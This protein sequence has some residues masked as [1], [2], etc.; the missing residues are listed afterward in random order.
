MN[1]Y[2][3]FISLSKKKVSCCIPMF[4]VM[5]FGVQEIKGQTSFYSQ[6]FE[7]TND[8]TF[9]HSI[10]SNNKNYWVFGLGTA[11]ATTGDATHSGTGSLQIWQSDISATYGWNANYSNSATNQYDRTAS[12]TFNFSSIPCG[13][14]VTFKYWVLCKGETGYDDLTVSVNSNVIQGPLSGITSWQQK[15]ID[16]SSFVGNSNV[17][18]SFN[19]RNN[20][21]NK[22]QPAARIDDIEIT[23]TP[24]ITVTPTTATICPNTI[25]AITATTPAT[26]TIVNETF[27][28]A[29]FPTNWATTV[30][31]GDAVTISSTNYA[32]GSA[33]EVEF[34]SNSQT[35]NIIDRLKYGPFNTSG[36]TSLTLSW[37]NYLWHYSSVYS[38]YV[39]LQTSSDGITWHDSTWGTNPV[40]AD[41]NQ[42]TE[43]ITLATADIGSSTTYISFTMGGLTFGAFYWYIDDVILKGSGFP[44]WAPITYL[45]SNSGATASYIL[46]TQAATVYFKSSTPGIYPYTATINGCTAT[47]TITVNALNTAAAAS[48]TPT[49]CVNTALTNITHVTTGATGISNSGVSGA[50]GLPAGL[51]AS[52][53]S[54]TITI[55]GTPTTSGTFN[56]SISLTGGCGS[57]NATGTITVTPLLGFVNLQ[58]PASG[59]IC[60]SGSFTA[61]G[62]VY[63]SGV[64]PGV[65]AGAGITVQFGYSFSNSDPSTWITWATANYNTDNGNNDE[66]QYTLNSLLAGTY[67]YAFRYSNGTCNWQ[68]GGYNSGGGGTWNGTSN[69]SGVLTVIAVPTTAAAG[70]DQT[71]CEGS[72]ITLAANSPTV[73]SGQWSIISGS[74][75]SIATISSPTSTFTGTI[76]TTYTLRW[77]TTNGICTT[78][79]DVVIT[80]SGINWANTQWPPNALICTNGSLTVFGQIYVAGL[81]NPAGAGAGIVAQLG[82]STTN[83]NPN[84]WTNW[85]PSVIN[86][87][88]LITNNNDEYMATLSG[89]SAA[90]YYYAFRYSLNGCPYKYGGNLNGTWNGVN[91]VTGDFWNGTTYVGGVLTVNQPNVTISG[92]TTICS[93]SSTT[94]TANGANTYLW[95]NSLTSNPITVSPPTSTTYTVTGTNSNNCTNTA[96]INVTVNPKPISTSIYHD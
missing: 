11:L 2:R 16:L 43:S 32:G 30:G 26:S 18:I 56:Y 5:V 19:W 37:K 71:I 36:Q 52:W 3:L 76:N 88:P 8:W 45:Y 33:N 41:M 95:S 53:A 10:Y 49:L 48:S 89:L 87:T 54:N 22:Y 90:T 31:A 46:N 38:Y 27:T 91:N 79:D 84:T 24:L 15:T 83:T 72:T 77:T 94:L 82:Y 12:K 86:P 66:Y 42:S 67:Y 81:T 1:L 51:S 61:Y 92:T 74:G 4:L 9:S 55:S 39:K 20:N 58:F 34:N 7:S 28:G 63:L 6:G 23:Y 70:L 93:G 47:S 75:G 85:I 50:N 59:T 17:A 64:T 78:S 29:S 80:I 44:T 25:Q 69:G 57:V 13:S 40:T 21:S 96:S 62:R 14:T 60:S 73:G 68:Y 35:V 65:G